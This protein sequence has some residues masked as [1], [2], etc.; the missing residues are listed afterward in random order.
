MSELIAEPRDGSNHQLISRIDLI[1][2][3]LVEQDDV[4]AIVAGIPVNLDM[5]GGLNQSIL[6]AAG[7]QIDDF[8][9][10]HIYKPRPGDVFAVPPFNLPIQH[11][12]YAVTPLWKDS[13]GP[14][15]R[16]L[17]RCY[18]AAMQMARQM[19]LRRVAFA[20]LGAGV[21]EFPIKRAARLGL[22]AILDRL[23]ESFAEIRIVAYRDDVYTAW[24]GILRY[25]GW[26]GYVDPTA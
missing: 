20:G 16:D 19:E 12:L 6:A 8:I 15:D 3:D 14:E 24:D 17:I 1:H 18:R 22:N 9:L 21:R 2:G 25:N 13:I 5:G 23:D 7:A 26:T 4:D 11:I 10:E